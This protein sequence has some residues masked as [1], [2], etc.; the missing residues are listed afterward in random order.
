MFQEG[1]KWSSPKEAVTL[2]IL[3]VG[4]SGNLQQTVMRICMLMIGCKGLKVRLLLKE[5]ILHVHQYTCLT[6]L[7]KYCVHL[8]SLKPVRITGN[9]N[10]FTNKCQT[11]CR[12]DVVLKVCQC[13]VLHGIIFSAID[14][15]DDETVAMI[16]ELLDT[17]IR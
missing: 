10:S 17:R 2:Q 3:L 6:S 13:S 1:R 15:D 14:E 11:M 7:V 9:P 12:P 8:K 4:T 16:K 5:K